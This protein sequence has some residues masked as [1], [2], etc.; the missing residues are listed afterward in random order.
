MAPST[1]DHERVRSAFLRA[2]DLPRP[3]RPGFVRRVLEDREDLAALALAMLEDADEAGEPGWDEPLLSLERLGDYEVLGLVGRGGMAVVLH[4][5]HVESRREVALKVLPMG[6]AS[7]A[8][9]ER[10]ER[11]SEV[12]R[13]LR[14]PDIARWRDGGVLDTPE[15]SR[16]FVAMDYFDGVSLLEW[17]ERERPDATRRLSVLERVARAVAFCHRQGVVHRDLKPSNVLVGARDR[18]CIL[19]Y[20]VAKV[21]GETVAGADDTL[22][23]SGQ[24]VGTVRFMSPE[25]AGGRTEQVGPATDVHALGLMIHEVM[26]GTPPY[27]VPTAL[28]EALPAI[29]HAR[30]APPDVDDPVLRRALA[31]IGEA[32]LERDPTRRLDDAALLAD[33]LVSAREGRPVPRRG[34]GT[35][36]GTWIGAP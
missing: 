20:G 9:R 12:L 31:A 32:T 15:G 24:L 18:I 36:R 29:V 2:L 5:V 21:L 23:Q 3:D 33:D 30:C 19:D 16:P 13:S 26:T 1:S 27:E 28:R 7:R 17:V 22:T 34:G 8:L 11:E 6:T 10:L 25:Q 14:H 35:R 4:A